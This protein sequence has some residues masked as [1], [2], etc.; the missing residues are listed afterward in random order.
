MPVPF[1]GPT[2]DVSAPRHP[3]AARSTVAAAGSLVLIGGWVPAGAVPATGP[4]VPAGS[5][6][7][8]AINAV[9]WAAP[10]ADPAAVAVGTR[11]VA[12]VR[13]DKAGVARPL[14]R[15]STVLDGTLAPMAAAM[16][17]LALAGGALSRAWVG[18]R[19]S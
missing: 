19:S 10:H 16:I 18:R 3:A 6:F 12:R 17:A 4:R 9:P 13:L 5:A 15:P 1:A 11:P 8:D 14:D 2:S 7:G